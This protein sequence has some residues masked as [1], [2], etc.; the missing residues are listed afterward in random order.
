M[1]NVDCIIIGG[2]M[3]GAASAIAIAD[4]G[5]KVAVVDQKA[6]KPFDVEQAMDLRVSAISLGS[7]Q[8]LTTLDCW[9][10][11]L[12]TRACPYRRLAVWEHDFAKTEFN[13]EEIAQ[14]HLGHIVENRILQLALWQ[15]LEK[16]QYVELLCPESLVN[17]TQY[18]T[19]VDVELQQQSVKAKFVLGADG[20]NSQV[21]MLSGIGSTGWDYK[22]SAMLVNIK[23]ESAQQDITWQ[24]FTPSGP[25]AFLPLV[26][27]FASLVWYESKENI[28]RLSSLSNSKLAIEIRQTFPKQLA[29]FEVLD[30]GAF[31][32]TRRHANLYVQNRIVLIGD[33]AHTINPLAG[34]GVNIGLKDVS[35]LQEVLATAI[36]NGEAFDSASVLTQYEKQRRRDNALMM[37]AMDGL[38]TTFSNELPLLKLARNAGLFLAG[39]VPVLKKK[40]LAYACGIS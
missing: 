27:N 16:H 7:E 1:L 26:D 18:E 17:F 2:G 28:A 33:A 35:V 20:A 36:A 19:H 11:V 21:R 13:A 37:T 6:P 32:L 14:P 10:Q 39:K 25:V 3:V 38:Y 31:P 23:L 4:L 22:Q 34:Q 40:A 9:Q 12:N 8:L 15:Q 5:L 24:Q 29:Q 30:K